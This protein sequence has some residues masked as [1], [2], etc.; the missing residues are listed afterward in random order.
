[1]CQGLRAI[2]GLVVVVEVAVVASGL[3][4]VGFSSAGGRKAANGLRMEVKMSLV[5]SM[6]IVRGNYVLQ[7]CR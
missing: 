6:V 2:V 5:R 1:M 7:G 4:G 3:L